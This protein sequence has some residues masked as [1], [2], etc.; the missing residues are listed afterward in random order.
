MEIYFVIEIEKMKDATI[1]KAIS[2]PMTKEAALS[3]FHQTL[4][5]AV[6]NPNVDSVYCEV[7]D[8]MGNS[9]ISEYRAQEVAPVEE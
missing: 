2:G 6:I 8:I 5:S 4:A 9:I 3:Q 1:P 7:K